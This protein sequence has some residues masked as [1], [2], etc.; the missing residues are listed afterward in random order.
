[1]GFPRKRH[2]WI[3]L[4]AITLVF[5]VI[6][7]FDGQAHWRLNSN[8]HLDD[9]DLSEGYGFRK[10]LED[11]LARIERLRSEGMEQRLPQCIIIGVRKCGTRALLEFLDLHPKIRIADMEMHF[12]NKDENYEKGYEWYTKYMPFSLNTDITIEKTP[13]YFISENAPERIQKMNHSI[14][15]IVI[16]RNPTTR[17]ISDYAQVYQNKVERNYSVERLEDIV[18]SKRTGRVN[19][20]Y[21][22]VRISMYYYHLTHWLQYFNRDQIHVVNGDNL[23]VNPLEEIHEVETF[24]GL[25]HHVTETNVYFN[26]TRGFFC[27]NSVDKQ[28]CLGATKGRKHPNIDSKIVKKLKNFYRPYN[29]KLFAMI[30][31][32]FDWD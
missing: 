2:V 1:M 19:T 17:V 23:I 13:R 18:I 26:E 4:T 6:L 9:T 11:P 20:G 12:F 25:N 16:F 24:L 27:M 32:E 28:H 10:L 15:L 30:G 8:M 14:K 21:K 5:C 3:V 22:A 7:I 31:K 29:R